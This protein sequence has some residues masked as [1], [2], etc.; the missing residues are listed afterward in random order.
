[1]PNK[2]AN[3]YQSPLWLLAFATAAAAF[4][5]PASVQSVAAAAALP[6]YL[7]LIILAAG[8]SNQ[9]PEKPALWNA[10]RALLLAEHLATT[11]ISITLML[12]PAWFF[13]TASRPLFATLLAAAALLTLLTLFINHHWL[14]V[15]AYQPEPNRRTA[16]LRRALAAV[17]A[18][19]RGKAQ[20]FSADTLSNA[21]Y[22]CVLALP[23][24]L[25]FMTAEQ[26]MLVMPW[27]G[28]TLL[29]APAVALLLLKPQIAEANANAK[30]LGSA[31][32]LASWLKPRTEPSLFGN[33]DA[34]A[35]LLANAQ[36]EEFSQL[37]AWNQESLAQAQR[38]RAAVEDHEQTLDEATP[39]LAELIAKTQQLELFGAI[40]Q[41][42]VERVQTLL[43]SGADANL[44]LSDRYRERRTP[45]L[46]A[47]S[48]GLSKIARALLAAGAEVNLHC[49]GQSAL[50]AATRDSWSGRFD[51]VMTLI[52]NGADVHAV[53]AD[54]NS[55]LH[56]AARSRDGALIRQLIEAGAD[57]SLQ[58][59]LGLSPLACAAAAGNKLGITELISHRTIAADKS[60]QGWNCATP[61]LVALGSSPQDDPELVKLLL[62]HCDANVQDAGGR[63]A[64]HACASHDLLDMGAALLNAGANPNLQ[65][66]HGCTPLM[67]AASGS[68]LR[69]LQLLASTSAS[70]SL[71][72]SRRQS[73]LHYLSSA[74]A[75]NLE[76][77]R[78][79]IATLTPAMNFDGI[80][81][82]AAELALLRGW[83]DLARLLNPEHELPGALEE[84]LEPHGAHVPDRI[85]LLKEAAIFNRLSVAKVMLK[86][87]PAP[88]AVL[89]ECIVS[90]GDNLNAD[91]LQVMRLGGLLLGEK[92]REPLLTLL[93][94]QQP[95]PKNALQLL[96]QN[97]ANMAPD[98][99]RDSLLNLVAGAAHDYAGLPAPQTFEIELSL[100][101]AILQRASSALLM[102]RDASLR[103]AL[104]W[105]MEFASP[106][107]IER[108]LHALSERLSPAQSGELLNSFDSEGQ[109]ALLYWLRRTELDPAQQLKLTQ[110]LIR[111]GAD[112][113]FV[114]QDG[115]SPRALALARG[116]VELGLVELLTW[117]AHSHPRRRLQAIDVPAA[118]KRGD[119]VALRRLLICGLLIDAFD[120]QG[121]TALSHAAGLGQM[122]MMLFLLAQG[123][124]PNAGA[125]PALHCALRAHA[126]AIAADANASPST[127]PSAAQF[128]EIIQ[129]LLRA[130][131]DIQL[132]PHG[133]DA[134]GTACALLDIDALRCLLTVDPAAL[135]QLPLAPISATHALM[136]AVLAQANAAQ[137][138][139]QANQLLSTLE[140]IFE[141]LLASGADINTPDPE[142]RSA[143]LIAVGAGVSTA[144]NYPENFE[145]QLIKLLI[146]LGSN[147]Q[148][149]DA[150]GRTAL[151]WC[152]RHRLLS[153]AEV[154]LNA[155]ADPATHDYGRKLP[156]DLANA[157]D[158]HDFAA[159]FRGVVLPRAVGLEKLDGQV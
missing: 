137:T 150:R 90:L 53:G 62:T 128:I 35:Q 153:S 141:V 63:S 136:H 114:G 159:L 43:K 59:A 154:L 37:L 41:N 70:V 99:E 85:E 127:A 94:R 20:I 117:P 8:I 66:Q 76:A 44:A 124:D 123:A 80:R 33:S 106:A 30:A 18:Q 16:P 57:V 86:L 146:K 56:H 120:A 98:S 34:S 6:V 119:L 155:G 96:L 129:T 36:N 3:W 73:A 144:P 140:A 152:A 11:L 72:D 158:R 143:L 54:G 22:L 12:I 77:A 133:I 27:L 93:A 88:Q 46:L 50:I 130:G 79:L 25:I 51:V 2:P 126:Q 42:D 157:V 147:T 39:P 111:A 122:P 31:S 81:R 69:F 4:Y 107:F 89:S 83:W 92:E 52:T 21:L 28:Y 139:E 17:N 112:P 58:N 48:L 100:L 1:M 74:D 101:D 102:H 132:A 7:W 135:R 138:H 156:I 145:R 84:A 60:A 116:D 149:L 97:G 108:L 78:L 118:A 47:A 45:L 40:L 91:W 29:L 115:Q 14:S 49:G 13:F 142:G 55:P 148:A 10:A 121:C 67:L 109:S 38:E 95:L 15:L 125:L 9:T 61:P 131:A 151:H 104:S 71:L 87:G 26:R 19:Q 5:A 75:P 134:L 82:N 110:A 24:A 23:F 113:N 65:D 103:H 68:S 32:E 105:A 64:L